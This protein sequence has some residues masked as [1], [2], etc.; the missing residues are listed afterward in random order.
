MK[1]NTAREHCIYLSVGK[2]FL[3]KLQLVNSELLRVQ[4]S[5]EGEEAKM[6]AL[7]ETI[8]WIKH[9]RNVPSET[10]VFIIDHCPQCSNIYQLFN[11]TWCKKKLCSELE[12][13]KLTVSIYIIAY[14]FIE[15]KYKKV[16]SYQLSGRYH[17]KT[18]LKKLVPLFF[19][20][21]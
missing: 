9:H 7:M 18:L 5:Q 21:C 15:L 20:F 3:N 17:K 14:K 16:T 2:M 13:C 4:Q 6:A 19:L 11:R 10:P 1:C 12:F 8:V